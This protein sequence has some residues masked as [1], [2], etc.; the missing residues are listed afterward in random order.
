M[1]DLDTRVILCHDCVLGVFRA[2]PGVVEQWTEMIGSLWHPF[3][4]EQCCEFGWTR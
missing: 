3:E 1:G 2:L 4:E